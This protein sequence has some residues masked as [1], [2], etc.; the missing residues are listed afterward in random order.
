R[1][2]GDPREGG[3]DHV[4]D[5]DVVGHRGPGVGDGDGV[6]I[7]RAAGRGGVGV[8]LVDGE[9]GVDG[10]ESGLRLTGLGCV[11]G[12]RAGGVVEGAL[13]RGVDGAGDD[14]GGG[15]AR[16][17]WGD[18]AAGHLGGHRAGPVA[19]GGGDPREG[20][21][22]HVGDVDVVGHRGPGVGDGDG[23]EMV[24]AGGGRVVGVEIVV[25]ECGVAGEESG[26][27]LSG[28]GLCGDGIV[29][30]VVVGYI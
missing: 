26:H 19:R 12:R 15:L 9:G 29:G 25:V 13:E 30:G 5:V 10:D 8:D 28:L 6:E 18:G 14:H 22:D 24:G 17:Q 1:G 11:V 23:V 4:G 16:G 2:G 7:G 20:G 21:G 27:Q 3:G